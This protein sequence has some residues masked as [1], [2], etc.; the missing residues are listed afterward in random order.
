MPTVRP[1][2]SVKVMPSRNARAYT[3]ASAPLPLRHS[4]PNPSSAPMISFTRQCRSPGYGPLDLLS[5]YYDNFVRKCKIVAGH[6]Q[7]GQP[8][9]KVRTI[10]RCDKRST[11]N[12]CGRALADGHVVLIR[13]IQVLVPSCGI[14]WVIPLYLHHSNTWCHSCMVI[15]EVRLLRGA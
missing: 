7:L 13:Q 5:W 10:L 14:I 2:T 1:D 6:P 11:H 12:R 3:A 8:T 4:T 15:V 9:T